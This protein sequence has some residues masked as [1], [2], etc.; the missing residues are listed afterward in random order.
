MSIYEY[1]TS[2]G[3]PVLDSNGDIKFKWHKD[4]ETDV[5]SAT[6]PGEGYEK[7]LKSE[8]QA[9]LIQL[10]TKDSSLARMF[11]EYDDYN[12]FV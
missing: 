11:V 8:A 5:Y 7:V 1:E 10:V 9:G 12:A 3:K 6:S 4:N 2:N